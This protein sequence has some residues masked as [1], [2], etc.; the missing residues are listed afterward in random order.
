MVKFA[1]ETKAD[2]VLIGTETGLL[3]RLRKENPDK[4]FI[5]IPDEA[6]CPNMKLITLETVIWSL[7]EMKHQVTVPESIRE[8]AHKTV[9]RMFEE[10]PI[11][12]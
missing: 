10:G 7:E 4:R 1:R 9:E 2:T 6:V 3:H 11:N 12:P 5:P 8:K